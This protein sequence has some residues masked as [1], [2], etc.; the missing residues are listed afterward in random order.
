MADAPPEAGFLLAGH[1]AAT[2]GEGGDVEG[3][4]EGEGGAGGRLE[5]YLVGDGAVFVFVAAAL[6]DALCFEGL[7]SMISCLC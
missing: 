2:F 6:A 4:G 3:V 1:A 7:V 5:E